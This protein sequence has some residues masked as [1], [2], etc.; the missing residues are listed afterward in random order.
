MNSTIVASQFKREN[1]QPIVW[2]Y[3]CFSVDKPESNPYIN[4]LILS[5]KSLIRSGTYQEQDTII[6]LTDP[7]SAKVLSSFGSL[8]GAFL[9]V[10]EQPSCVFEGVLNR[11]LILQK[12]NLP[13]GTRCVYLDCDLLFLKKWDPRFTKLW[14][15][16][17]EGR[18]TDGNYCGDYTLDR[19]TAGCSSTL[20]GFIVST[21]TKSILE[22]TYINASRR[23]KAFYT[24]DQPYY[25]QVL[26]LRVASWDYFPSNLLSFNGHNNKETAVIL[27]LCGD[28]GDGPLHFRKM[29]DCF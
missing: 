3:N 14:M 7:S 8:R 9:S 18:P 4:C 6:I 22:T 27:N 23:G 25:N 21:E 19:M 20:F 17:P 26:N 28:P 2:Y 29:L 24:L 12:V 11:Y 13:D 5:I 10:C 1:R 16:I 15:A